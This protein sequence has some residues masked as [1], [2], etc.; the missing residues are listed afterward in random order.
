MQVM[1]TKKFYNYAHNFF[2]L[3]HFVMYRLIHFN[4]NNEIYIQ[5]NLLLV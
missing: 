4:S 2:Y 3:I 5:K 1:K